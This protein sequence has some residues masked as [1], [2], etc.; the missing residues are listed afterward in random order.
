MRLQPFRPCTLPDRST[1]SFLGTSKVTPSLLQILR[2]QAKVR[3]PLDFAAAL[4][5]TLA[6]FESLCP[7]IGSG[8]MHRKKNRKGLEGGRASRKAREGAKEKGRFEEETATRVDHLPPLV[9]LRVLFHS[10]RRELG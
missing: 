3:I 10:A 5:W 2:C 7:K 8:P 1:C 4:P 9:I 6:L